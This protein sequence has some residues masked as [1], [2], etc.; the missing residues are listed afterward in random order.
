MI[1]RVRLSSGLPNFPGLPRE[2]SAHS[3]ASFDSTGSVFSRGLSHDTIG[4]DSRDQDQD[5]HGAEHSLH[6]VPLGERG[7]EGIGSVAASQ[8]ETVA[9]AFSAFPVL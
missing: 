5:G 3:F 7:R 1:G 9:Q 2:A 8:D 4:Q 6:R